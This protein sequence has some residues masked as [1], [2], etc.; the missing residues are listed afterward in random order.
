MEELI[1]VSSRLS[2]LLPHLYGNIWQ[3]KRE[4]VLF[5]QHNTI[6]RRRSIKSANK[7]KIFSYETKQ[8]VNK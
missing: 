6:H 4:Y 5:A 8:I 3:I 7:K 1:F 2:A